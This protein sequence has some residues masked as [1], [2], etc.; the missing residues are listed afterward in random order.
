[1]SRVAPLAGLRAWLV[2]EG[3]TP[4]VGAFIATL[5]ISGLI[6]VVNASAQL[7]TDQ[8]SQL[9][10]MLVLAI[11]A[12]RVNVPLPRGGEFSPST[13]VYTTGVLLLPAHSAIVVGF[14][15]TLVGEAL[16]RKPWYRA[17]F[18]VGQATVNC[19]V[20]GFIWTQIGHGPVVDMDRLLGSLPAAFLTITFYYL[21]NSTLV[22]G[23]LALHRG[24]MLWDVWWAN[25]R[26]V[27]LPQMGLQ[28]MGILF[29]GAW[30]IDWLAV[31]LLALPAGMTWVSYRQVRT[32]EVKAQVEHEL[33]ERSDRMAARW[34]AL[35]QI[36]ERL[37]ATVDPK[38]LVEIAAKLVVD[39]CAEAAC[40]AAPGAGVATA[41]RSDAPAQ[42]R[43][44]LAA[45]VATLDG[46]VAS[47]VRALPLRVGDQEVGTLY[48][49]WDSGVPTPDQAALLEPLADRI[50]I[51]LQNTLLSAEAGEVQALREIDR[52]KG[53]LLASV[54]H[55]LK[56]PIALMVGYGELLEKRSLENEQARWMGGKILSAGRHLTRLVDDLLDAGRLESGRFTL[57]RRLVDLRH[58][59][60]SALE[61]ARVAHAGPRFVADLPPAPVIVEGDQSRLLQ[62][63][64]N[65]LS[66]AARYGPLDGEIR[67]TMEPNG[68]HA[69]IGIEDQGP[70]V[71]PAE[72]ERI[73]EKFYRAPG[74]D[75]RSRKGLGLGLTIVRDLVAAHGGKV[76]VDD[77]PW[78]G[79]RF[80]VEL[81]RLD[82]RP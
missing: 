78:G 82:T 11:V 76:R 30:L 45:S 44:R 20:S 26:G 4:R 8:L 12:E 14:V 9:G 71:P 22:S 58:V 10:A 81:P 5:A 52:M 18:N 1:V 17:A 66:N 24:G 28:I 80:I 38:E 72:R 55:E 54:S 56:T 13:M 35:A 47:G 64:T 53:D 61:T 36:G 43:A 70:G 34:E 19:A 77:A 41:V 23:V 67:L 75:R 65:L 50:A 33:R 79:A 63:L 25:H 62:V 59:A 31:V 49:A 39:Q 46:Y 21:L 42:L 69:I 15:G 51:A 48:A 60:E 16:A 32:L 27:L 40:V 29:V 74:A 3:L 57:D 2:A 6:L 68:V 7:T 37:S 73:F